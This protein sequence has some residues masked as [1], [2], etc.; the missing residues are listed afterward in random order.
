MQDMAESVP[1]KA[2]RLQQVCGGKDPAIQAGFRVDQQGNNGTE[3]PKGS[4]NQ[5]EA[6]PFFCQKS[7]FHPQTFSLHL[8]LSFAGVLMD[9]KAY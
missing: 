6:L 1:C 3:A 8:F 4:I 5:G 9:L 7:I 2:E